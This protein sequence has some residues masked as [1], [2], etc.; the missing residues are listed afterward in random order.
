MLGLETDTYCAARPGGGGGGQTYDHLSIALPGGGTVDLNLPRSAQLDLTC[1][2]H[3]T[4]FSDPHYPQPEPV[5]PLSVLRASLELPRTSKVGSVLRFIVALRNPTEQ[6]VGLT[7]CPGYVEAVNTA[8]PDKRT[9][10]LNCA[11]VRSIGPGQTVRFAMRLPIPAGSSPGPA[12][13]LWS[14]QAPNTQATGT[15]V[16]TG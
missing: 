2:L 14:L 6:R 10:A 13:V 16:V 7:P 11:P 1:G 12:R 15:V 5:Y 9:Y 8:T 4:G 3:S